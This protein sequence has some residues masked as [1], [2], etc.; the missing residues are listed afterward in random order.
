MKKLI[1][2]LGFPIIL[3]AV[4]ACNFKQSDSQ[5]SGKEQT[6]VEFRKISNPE[7]IL[8]KIVVLY[9]D[10]SNEPKIKDVNTLL[11]EET[12]KERK[13]IKTN[14]I[15][16][17]FDSSITNGIYS[18][19]MSM[20]LV[21]GDYECYGGQIKSIKILSNEVINDKARIVVELFNDNTD[22]FVIEFEKI[23]SEW[24][25]TEIQTKRQW[26]YYRK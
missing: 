6:D 10:L 8:K 9:N 15:N 24:K 16:K 14:R 21:S 7:E 18:P 4:T 22:V 20:E 2:V 13:G 1:I 5:K 23:N 3:F 12:I 11:D 17:F 19:F 26:D 25:I